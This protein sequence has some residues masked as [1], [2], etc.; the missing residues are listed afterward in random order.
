ML[1]K[2]G[3]ITLIQLSSSDSNI[4]LVGDIAI[5]AGT[6]FNFTR[7]RDVMRVLKLDL[8]SIKEVVNTHGHFDHVGGDGYFINAKIA[9]HEAD[10]PVVEKGD[11]Q[12]SVADF[13]D[14]KLKPRE[15]HRKLK[16]GDVVKAG[17]YELQVVHTPGHSPGSICLLDKRTGTLFSGDTVFANSVG[18][19]DLPGSDPAKLAE[20][21]QKLR[22]LGVKRILP[23]HGDPVLQ[24]ADKVL[25]SAAE[26]AEYI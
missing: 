20:S 9:V 11:A 21:I 10:A 13:F 2:I 26:M 19:T 22:K 14:G 7:L 1:R 24:G 25:S 6:G 17:A 4:Y 5:D 23:G 3:D 16:D 15:V 8:G 12:A 18:R